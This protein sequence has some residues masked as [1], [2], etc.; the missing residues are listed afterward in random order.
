MIQKTDTPKQNKFQMFQTAG[1]EQW[2]WV[3]K[4]SSLNQ[5]TT[6]TVSQCPKHNIEKQKKSYAAGKE[7]W[8]WM[9]K[10]VLTNQSTTHTAKQLYKITTPK[11]LQWK[12]KNKQ[13]THPN[14]NPGKTKDKTGP[15]TTHTKKIWVK[16][17]QSTPMSMIDQVQAN[18][19]TKPRQP[20]TKQVKQK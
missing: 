7:Q 18:G 10:S 6:H 17:G 11:G 16:K 9:K 1:K 5:S 19:K 4:T 2:I 12:R 8:I 15:T 13:A 14:T 20:K 3:Q